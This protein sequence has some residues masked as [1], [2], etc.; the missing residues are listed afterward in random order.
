M[1][2]SIDKPGRLCYTII[3]KREDP[4]ERRRL[5]TRGEC[6][7]EGRGR[8]GGVNPKSKKNLKKGLTNN[9]DCGIIITEREKNKK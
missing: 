5:K 9:P 8:A 4:G 6:P 3:R 7:R 1:K 2:K